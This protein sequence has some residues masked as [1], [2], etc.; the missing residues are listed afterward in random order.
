M[1]AKAASPSP[2]PVAAVTKDGDRLLL[3]KVFFA[4][5]GIGQQFRKLFEHIPGIFFF[6]KDAQSRM[7]YVSR[8][9]L[10]RF[11]LD[12]EADVVGRTDYEFF[13][14]QIA[15]NFVRDDQLVLATGQPLLNKVEIWYNAQRI[16][17]W[18]VTTKLPVFDEEGRVMGIM[19][20]VHSYAHRRKV[21][22][23][24]SRLGR[25]LDYIDAHHR[26]SIG[27]A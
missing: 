1:P 2:C 13:P 9:I 25:V 6:V 4:R 15:D 22:L 24:N 26:E 18:F 16:L 3:Q 27:V 5:M 17:D 19:G 8:P 10:E 7:I 20:I 14:S 23:R 12:E 21:A 11:G